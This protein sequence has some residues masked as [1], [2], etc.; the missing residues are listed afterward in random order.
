MRSPAERH[1]RVQFSIPAPKSDVMPLKI[2]N[3]LSRKKEVFKV[4]SKRINAFVCGPTVYDYSH[5]GH[6]RTYIAYD[7]MARWLR[8]NGYKLKFLM[9]ITD[10]DDKI[11]N[12]AKERGINPI[13]LA[14]EYEKIFYEDMKALGID[15]IDIF[16]RAS[17]HIGEIIDQIK[18]LMKGGL[19]YETKTGIYFDISKFKDYGKL[20][21]QKPEELDR[22]RIE[23]DPT[24]KNP[25]D[26]SLWKKQSKE[27][28]GWDSPYGYG[29][30]GWH[31][32][33]T[34]ISEKYLGQQ[35][36]IHGGGIDLIFPHHESEIVQ[37]ESVSGKKPM[38]KYWLHTGFL[39]V[40]GQKMSKSL[41]NFII[42]RDVLK[43]YEP[44]A[45]RLFFIST[46]YRSPIDFSE[47][48]LKEA[49]T[50]LERMKNFV[51]SLN[52]SLNLKIKGSES[53]PLGK[54]LKILKERFEGAMDDDF[55]TPMALAVL[56]EYMKI[57]NKYI[58][59]PKSRKEIKLAL[60]GFLEMTS[61]LGLKF[62]AKKQ[63]ISEGIENLIKERE[64]LRKE[65]KFGEADKI[66]K[67]LYDTGVILEDTPQGPKW[68]LK[69]N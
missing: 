1:S 44:T 19:A 38:V 12:R 53:S 23:L 31:I 25:H 15:T 16:A 52:S 61:I 35:Y 11:I 9:N 60:K 67:K 41:G 21:N 59:K 55:N 26:F 20:S 27:E 29:R 10:V 58:E 36:D 13:D 8:H 32:E 51:E 37:M 46:H 3:T 7:V 64:E 66:R 18:R 2:Y 69:N 65:K 54:K 49:R 28:L 63:K 22:H 40:G 47:S 4:P 5:I 17:E 42:I 48:A 62:E 39:L 24:K 6:A 43:D 50:N 56:F 57:V 30:P 14:R 33:D 34:A 68:K 45:L